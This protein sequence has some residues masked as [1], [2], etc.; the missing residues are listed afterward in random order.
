MPSPPSSLALIGVTVI[1]C[2]SP[3]IPWMAIDLVSVVAHS[4]KEASIIIRMNGMHLFMA[5]PYFQ[6]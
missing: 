5:S 1:V 4:M 2:T 3:R 6:S